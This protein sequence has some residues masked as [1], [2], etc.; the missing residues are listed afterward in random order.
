VDSDS[1]V[2]RSVKARGDI[3]RL[4]DP[5]FQVG[6]SS[7]TAYKN[8]RL[9]ILQE[10]RVKSCRR[11]VVGGDD[12]VGF[13]IR[14]EPEKLLLRELFG[15]RAEK[16]SSAG[17]FNKGD[18]GF[19]IIGKVVVLNDL[20]A[21]PEEFDAGFGRRIQAFCEAAYSKAFFE[22]ALPEEFGGAPVVGVFEERI[23]GIYGA[24]AAILNNLRNSVG[25][26]DVIVADNNCIESAYPAVVQER[27]QDSS[28]D[29][30]LVQGAGVKEKFGSARHLSENGLPVTDVQ[31]GQNEIVAVRSVPFCDREQK[32]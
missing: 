26:V 18:E 5:A 6:G 25:V 32:Y 22:Q 3:G 27:K 8:L 17:E 15:V 11:A 31:T 10:G 20:R 14:V 2:G 1:A 9:Q 24:D 19:V 4:C 7:A 29:I 23:V 21:G 13:Q 30:V 16:Y 28:S 12:N